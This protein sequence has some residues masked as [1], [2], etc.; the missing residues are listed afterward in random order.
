MVDVAPG[1]TLNDPWSCENEGSLSIE[2]APILNPATDA[3]RIL[4]ANGCY[5]NM[6]SS[7]RNAFGH[8]G[9]GD[10]DEKDGED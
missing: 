3:A 5:L 4:R 2:P 7:Q 10:C 9:G 6:L 8:K 1:L